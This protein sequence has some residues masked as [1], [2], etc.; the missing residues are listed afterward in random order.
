MNKYPVLSISMLAIAISNLPLIGAAESP[1]R[2]PIRTPMVPKIG[3]PNIKVDPQIK[4]RSGEFLQQLI[5]GG[6]R[7]SYYIYTP[8]TKAK[9]RPLPVIIGLHGGRSTPRNFSLTT[10]FNRLAERQGFIVIYPTGIDRQWQDGRENLSGSRQDDVGFINATIDDLARIRS[11]DNRRIYVAGMSNGGMMA[12]RLACQL[13]HRIAAVATVAA[14]MPAPLQSSCRSGKPLSMMAIGSPSDR[15]VPW[16]GGPVTRNAG[17]TVLSM[18]QTIDL[19]RTKAGCQ[20]VAR[21]RILPDTSPRDRLLVKVSQ[22]QGCQS[23]LSVVLVT[24]NGG[25]HTWPGGLAQSKRLGVTSTKF[26]AT[27]FIW[28]FFSNQTRS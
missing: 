19:W 5:Y 12:Q 15:I 28:E 14:A 1:P 13:P 4:P 6:K 23:G 2:E 20:A 10:N 7:R 27:E 18:P 16:Q 22:Y 11:I 17:G 3:K 8:K 21:D 26:D 25:G 24:V 9:N